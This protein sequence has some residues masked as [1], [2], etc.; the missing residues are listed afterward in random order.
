VLTSTKLS[1]HLGQVDLAPSVVPEELEETH[2]HHPLT[3]LD[4]QS[5]T[6][7][8]DEEITQES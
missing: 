6:S 1:F 8:S 3:L 4:T 5:D 7:S 2:E